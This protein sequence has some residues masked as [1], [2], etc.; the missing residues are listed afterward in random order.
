M[1][2]PQTAALFRGAGSGGLGPGRGGAEGAVGF[3]EQSTVR[4]RACPH[5]DRAGVQSCPWLLRKASPVQEATLR[6]RPLRD[7]ARS[8]MT[9]QGS[10]A[11][12]PDALC[13]TGVWLG[14]LLPPWGQAPAPGCA[15]PA[16]PP[17]GLHPA[18]PGSGLGLL[19]HCTLQALWEGSA[20]L[21]VP[22]LPR[23]QW[24]P[25]RPGHR[26]HRVHR[27]AHTHGCSGW[28]WAPG[29]GPSLPG[30]GQRGRVQP[31]GV[32]AAR[33]RGCVGDPTHAA[34]PPWPPPDLVVWH[35]PCLGSGA[36][37]PSRGCPP[38]CHL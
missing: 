20:W 18:R 5:G 9:S 26:T 2:P 35:E 15:H 19:P 27:W 38:I 21:R 29:S 33:Q 7:S 14:R 16:A 31:W 17:A 36:A 24:P 11:L 30:W 37:T 23:A 8:P 13:S 32:G 34:S 4:G 22:S 10:L 3:S 1:R 6:S 28:R 25:S 12:L